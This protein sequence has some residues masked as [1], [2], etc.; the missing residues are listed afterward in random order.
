M[1]TIKFENLFTKEKFECSIVDL[2]KPELIEG[3]AY[4]RVV[5]DGTKRTMLMRKDALK[6]VSV[7]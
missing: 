4:I 2:K 7:K 3:V 1:K 5:K 6:K